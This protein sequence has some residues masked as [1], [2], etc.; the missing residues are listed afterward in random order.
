LSEGE[1]VWLQDD[2][3]D[4]PMSRPTLYLNQSAELDWLIALPFGLVDDG[5]PP[6][7]W[8]GVSKSFGFLHDGPEGP[9]LGFKVLELSQFDAE[10]AEVAEIW[11]EPRFDV[12]VLGL[13]GASA[14]EIVLAVRPLFGSGDSI[15]RA[16]FGA[17]I[18]AEAKEEALAMW[19]AC[20][21]A[22]DSMAH[23]G[24]GYTLHDLGRF[25]EAYRHLRHYTEIAPCGSWNWCWLGKA[26]AAIGEIAEARAAYERA[27]EL[28]EAGGEET[29]APE[30]LEELGRRAPG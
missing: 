12:P 26:A 9:A 11:G 27:V 28:T 19:V 16:Y 30:L 13:R 25:P 21:Q 7:N 29:D 2:L 20:L 17:A 15:N 22:G 23:F 1:P 18:R 3:E 24:L 4:P 6:G 10:G 5:Q 14:G 8:R